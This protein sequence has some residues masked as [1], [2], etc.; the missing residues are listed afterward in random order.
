MLLF[1]LRKGVTN[2]FA[3][4]HIKHNY[5]TYSVF[6]IGFNNTEDE[7]ELYGY[8]REFSLSSSLIAERSV[9]F[10]Q[11]L[12]IIIKADCLRKDALTRILNKITLKEGLFQSSC[13]NIALMWQPQSK[14]PHLYG[15]PLFNQ[16]LQLDQI[17]QDSVLCIWVLAFTVSY[18][19]WMLSMQ[20]FFQQKYCWADNF[21]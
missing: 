17:F 16:F 8:V 14:V 4:L 9:S 10:E 21:Q 13:L 6:G 12:Q 2:L 3:L 7:C 5:W 19:I 1:Y 20:D 11:S 15:E 18:H